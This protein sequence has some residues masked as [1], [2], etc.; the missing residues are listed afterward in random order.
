VRLRTA[1]YLNATVDAEVGKV[2][3][4]NATANPQAK[5][6]RPYKQ[7]QTNLK[8][9]SYRADI[10]GLRAVAILP[11]ILFHFGLG[12]TPGGFVGVDVFFVISGYLITQHVFNEMT[13]GTFTFASF[14]ERRIRRIAPALLAM[15][16]VTTLA[17][18][19]LLLPAELTAEAKSLAAA[20]AS[21]ANIYFWKTSGYFQDQDRPLLHTWS[22]SVEEQFYMVLPPLLLLLRR[23]C[24]HRLKSAIAAITVI[25]FL[26]ASWGVFHSPDASFFLLPQR[27]WELSLGSLLG[28]GALP[29]P[30]SAIARQWVALVGL[31]LILVSVFQLSAAY[32]F[33]GLL[34]LPPCAGALMI[35]AAG[36][37]GSS[38]VSSLLSVPPLRFIGLI[39]YSL[40]LWH[41]PVI[42][43]QKYCYRMTFGRTLQALFPRLGFFQAQR[44][45]RIL[46]FLPLTFALAYLSWRFIEQPF[47]FGPRRLSRRRAFVYCGASALAGLFLSV[48]IICAKGLP[49]R[50]TPEANKI[51]WY[52]TT[53][54][55]DSLNYRAGTCFVSSTSADFDKDKCLHVEDQR[56]NWLLLGDSQAAQLWGGLSHAYPEVNVMQATA[57]GCEPALKA[58]VG[59]APRCLAIIQDVFTNFLPQH[60]NV[61]VILAAKWESNDV[62]QLA[63]TIEVLKAAGQ[64]VALVGPDLRYDTPLAR[65]LAAEASDGNRSL[66]ETHRL[67]SYDILDRQL[68]QR[69]RQ[70]WKISY[71]SY[72]ALL[73]AYGRCE[74]WAEKDIPLEFDTDHLTDAGSILVASRIRSHALL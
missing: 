7:N 13:A 53:Q 66:V 19:W 60:R 8:N 45:E 9:P 3:T 55:G 70:E 31:C 23:F 57:S 26:W 12:Y 71:I 38:F 62:P 6:P 2:I 47:R 69:A 51:A 41:A 43:L 17:A 35:I 22:L 16:I 68:A 34:A 5:A 28:L 48:G 27:A 59:D 58:R 29:I 18:S 36:T 15:L 64:R 33:P 56:D 39:S 10:D 30:R 21:V 65:L 37:E 50:L 46:V 72:P 24:P 11:V 14:Y 49:G 54:Y 42:V 74:V 25:S 73:C 32:P 44:L 52:A 1:S 61:L 4:R 63:R 40:Y 67:E 20:I